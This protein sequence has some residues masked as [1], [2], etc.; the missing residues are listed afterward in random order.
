MIFDSAVWCKYSR[1]ARYFIRG[2]LNKDP[3]MRM[4][5]DE[6]IKHGWIETMYG[7][8]HETEEEVAYAKRSLTVTKRPTFEFPS[9][10]ESFSGINLPS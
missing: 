5:M 7:A 2:L 4:N 8:W 10:D 9:V 1:E 6:M 3:K